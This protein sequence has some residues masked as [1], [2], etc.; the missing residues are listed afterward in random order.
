MC[1]GLRRCLSLAESECF[2][3]D[4]EEEGR[5]TRLGR[6]LDREERRKDE[7]LSFF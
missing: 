1:G 3:R 4:E 2:R 7:T 5:I 6:G